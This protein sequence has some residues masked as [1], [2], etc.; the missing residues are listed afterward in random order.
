MRDE[1]V[2][3]VNQLDNVLR[4]MGSVVVAMSGGVDS[5]FYLRQHTRL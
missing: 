5:T 1:L 3:K 2:E 4:Q